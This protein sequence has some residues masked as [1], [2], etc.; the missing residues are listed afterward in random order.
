MEAGVVEVLDVVG[1][2]GLGCRSGGEGE[3]AESFVLQ[4]GE[5]RFGGGVV[6]ALHF[7]AHGA[8]D[9]VAAAVL[10]ELPRPILG[11]VVGVEDAAGNDQAASACHLQCPDDQ[12]GGHSGAGGMAQNGA[13][14]QIDYCRHI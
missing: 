12:R 4:L 14:G 2:F 11:A 9:A 6:P 3:E 8:V 13:G 10:R 5:E 1:D 7:G